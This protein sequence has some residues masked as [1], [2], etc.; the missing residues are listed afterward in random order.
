MEKR[1]FVHTHQADDCF[2]AMECAMLLNSLLQL[3]KG[4]HPCDGV[5]EVSK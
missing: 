3:F 1:E 4:G 2:G 5:D